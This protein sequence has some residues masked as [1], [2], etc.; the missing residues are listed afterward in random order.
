VLVD[1]GFGVRELASR[2]ARIGLELGSL[3]AVLVTHEHGDH[4]GG[5]A[6]VGR[7]LKIPLMM[8]RGTALGRRDWTGCQVQHISPHQSFVL[9][10]LDVQPFPVPH[11]AR[12]PCHFTFVHESRRLGVVSDLG[13]VTPHVSRSLD[14]CNAL[15]LEFNHDVDM[16]ARGPY[17]AQLKRRVAGDL[18]H[19]SNIQ[20][21]ELLRGLDRSRLQALV[22][23]HISQK[24]N[25]PELARAAAC[26]ALDD[27]PDWCICA[28]QD[29]GS[30]WR[31]VH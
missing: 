30:G 19:L 21:A 25:T 23:T 16:L 15:L 24:N 5:V 29:H 26:E 9:G 14:A 22:L 10:D 31:E 13:H 27:D 18:G 6:R 20:A 2:A 28:E 3:D 8:T 4:I 11:D 17:P 12:E 1:C 7:A